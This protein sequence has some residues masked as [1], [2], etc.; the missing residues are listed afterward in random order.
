MKRLNELGELTKLQMK[1]CTNPAET[2]MI[3]LEIDRRKRVIADT[4][5]RAP[6]EDVC[7]NILWLAM[8]PMTRAH[9]TGKVDMDTVEFSMLRQVV[10]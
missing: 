2:A 5:G 1:K 3:I 9:V 6:G 10:Q 7:R 8:D 4:G